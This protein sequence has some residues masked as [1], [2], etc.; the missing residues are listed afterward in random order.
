MRRRDF[1]AV[2]GAGLIS[3]RAFGQKRLPRVGFLAT[4]P[5]T[6]LYSPPF[7]QA[8]R[9]IGYVDGKTY[10]FDLRSVVRAD[11]LSG[12]A[13]ALVKDKPDVI[14]TPFAQPTRAAGDATST[15][16]I[17]FVALA[18]ALATGLVASLNRPGGHVT[19]IGGDSAVANAKVLEI[20][21]ELLPL[22][23][24]MALIDPTNPY[25]KQLFEEVQRA[26]KRLGVHVEQLPVRDHDALEEA[27]SEFLKR[28]KPDAA[29]VEASFPKRAVQILLKAGVP[30][31]GTN[32]AFSA[33]GSLISY[34]GDTADMCRKVAE[35]V[36]RILRGTKP[37]ELP[38]QAPKRTL[39]INQKT[40]RSLGITVP[41]VV[42]LRADKVIE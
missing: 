13:A 42:L 4:A 6:E 37:A 40:A 18:D 22:R 35:Y 21:H 28:G 12:A 16:P 10:H 36:Q 26:G 9:D 1:V 32:G 3:R 41:D 5:L 39:I 27:V 2:A 17:V 31:G 11:Q 19:G 33:A 7:Q 38:V 8:M 30:A 23:R 14:V 20:L 25:S 34:A 29:I 15:I 24:A